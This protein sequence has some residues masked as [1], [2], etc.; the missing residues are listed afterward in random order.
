MTCERV[1]LPDGG[2]AIVCSS[3]RR[4]R[5]ACGAPATLL[6]DWKVPGRRTGTC[7]APL[8]ERFDYVIAGGDGADT[9][10]RVQD[11]AGLA[12]A[13]LEHDFSLI[14]QLNDLGFDGAPEFV[15]AFLE[16][17]IAAPRDL[18]RPLLVVVDEAQRFV[19]RT[20]KTEAV[21]GVKALVSQGRK[22]GFT[23]ILAGTKLTEID[24]A[25]RAQCNNW[26][27][28]RVGQSLDRKTMAE[29]LGFTPR[30]ARERLQAM[31]QRQFWAMG[32]ALAREPVLFHVADV[33]TTP[34]RAGQAKVPTPPAPEAL[35]FILADLAT[36][37][38]PESQ[39]S[40]LNDADEITRVDAF[41]RGISV[42]RREA[43]DRIA[44][45][46]VEVEKWRSQ[47]KFRG[48]V[49]ERAQAERDQLKMRI[50]MIRDA[51]DVPI[52]VKKSQAKAG[53]DASPLQ[54]SGDVE[55][56]SRAAPE[57]SRA[58]GTG[59][60]QKASRK[61]GTAG[62]TAPPR[63][64]RTGLEAAVMLKAIAPDGMEWN[65][66]LL[67][68]GR[69][70]NSGDSHVARKALRALGLIA[71]GEEVTATESLCLD[72]SIP[73]GYWPSSAELVRTWADK[74]RGPGGDILRALFEHGPATA[75]DVADRLGRSPTSGWWHRGMK[76]LR[77]SNLVRVDG[78]VL[79]LHPFLVK[80]PPA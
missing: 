37:A 51:L 36:P 38:E 79:T 56:V 10:A 59:A 49:L 7:D 14:A 17:L 33:A 53:A 28:G 5:C 19:P 46:E 74:L 50:G 76:D 27:L 48:E 21:A 65:D 45:L 8:R 54:P 72:E 69:R 26:L 9:S 34:V 41:D 61:P 31:E 32:P 63:L 75:G 73:L 20:G 44:A 66:V 18:W 60:E 52:F 78:Q 39:N 3:R 1:T 24:P 55:P 12:M 57:T 4:R 43:D 68:I 67:S 47:F 22:R 58:V 16:A 62:E 71:E 70:P 35:R 80:D 77:N 13:A 30:E 23:A 6:C 15:G 25:V 40:G 42:G 11:A 2:A 64:N 29:Q